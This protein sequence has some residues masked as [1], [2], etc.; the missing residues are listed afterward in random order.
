MIQNVFVND[1]RRHAAPHDIQNHPYVGSAIAGEALICPAKRMGGK[2]DIVEL[3][4]RIIGDTWL[5]LE[6]IETCRRDFA[7]LLGLG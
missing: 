3:I 1:A 5:F 2:D 7:R 4:E 6:N